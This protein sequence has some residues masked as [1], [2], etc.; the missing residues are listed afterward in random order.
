MRVS[1]ENALSLALFCVA[2]RALGY[3]R[4]KAQPSCVETVKV[5]GKPFVFGIDLLQPEKNKLAKVRDFE[6]PDGEAVKQVAVNGQVTTS[7]VIPLIFLVN[8][9]A[10]QVRH[11][12]R[13]TMVVVPFHPDH[14]NV[15]LRVG[16][17]ANVAE[18]LP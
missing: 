7:G 1:T 18:K 9:H 16:Q 17:L 5:A 2:E 3:L 11:D 10:D 15:V 12:L 6:I 14:F 8:L 13:Q 4:R